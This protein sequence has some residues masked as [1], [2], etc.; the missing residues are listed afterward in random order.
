MAG[1]VGASSQL[2]AVLTLVPGGLLADRA[3]RKKLLRFGHLV[4]VV[5][6]SVA[7]ALW[8]LGWLNGPTMIALGIVTGARSGLFR[9][10]SDAAIKQVVREDQLAA[11]TAAN[12]GRDATIMLASGP[13]GGL[14][15]GIS[16]IAPFIAQVIG[17]AVAWLTT[18]GIRVSLDPRTEGEDPTPWRMQIRE[19]WA[20]L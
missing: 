19:G 3:D 11:A 6:W 13:A 10:A 15:M 12:Q 4:G 5:S 20:W 1:V 7:I 18:R 9:S 17:H 2:A 14:L 16:T 8:W